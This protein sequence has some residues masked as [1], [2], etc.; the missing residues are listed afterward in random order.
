M[1]IGIIREGKVPPDK[2]VPLSPAECKML[3]EKHPELEIV[4]QPSPIRCF[5]DSEYEEAGVPVRENL[6]DCD[7][8]MGVKEVSI[9][10]LIANKTYF[11]FSHTIKKQPYNRNLLQQVLAKN[12]R[13]VDYETL[14][15]AKGLRI[16]GFGRWAGI[17]GA[18]NGLL[19]YGKR[20]GLF[21][22][23]PAHLC[24]DCEELFSEVQKISLPSLKIVVTGGGRVS[25]G[26][27]EVLDRMKVKKVSVQE[28]LTNENV[29]EAVYV[30]LEPGDYNTKN[31]GSIFDLH[32][33]FAHP[34]MYESTFKPYC[35]TTDLL[36]SAAYWDPKAPVLFTAEDMQGDDFRIKVIADITCDI[37]GSIPST[38]KASTIDD[39]VYDYNPIT[40]ELEAPFSSEKNISV[41]AVDNL[42]C[43]LPKDASV[44]FGEGIIEKVIPSLLGDDKD[45]VIAR[46]TIAKNGK[47]TERFSYLQ[48]YVDG[49]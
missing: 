10:D 5:N 45:G 21:D 36:V 2:R 34:E 22:L 13:L 12:I 28:Y 17:V 27:M 38:K 14:T 3:L 32:D 11:F 48:D 7:V 44:G 30:Q 29:E 6:E 18:Y 25:H 37:E 23:K 26:V 43:E 47:L 41:M 20:N 49:I 15:D 19:T 42:P 1:K 24:F 16:I 35:S 33:F 46:A 31:G 4:V 8:L 9:K 39:P 40:G